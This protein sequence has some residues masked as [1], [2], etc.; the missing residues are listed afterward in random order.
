MLEYLVLTA[1][2]V[3]SPVFWYMAPCGLE[4]WYST[5]FVCVPP[6]IISLQLCIPKLLVYNSSYTQSIIYIQNKLN[7]L[8]PK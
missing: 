8:H 7:K 3:N 5:F 6:D 4:Q 1:A 2:D